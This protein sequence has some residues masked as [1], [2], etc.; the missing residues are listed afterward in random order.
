M[1]VYAVFVSAA[2]A[3]KSAQG[4]GESVSLGR[5]AV[6]GDGRK[7]EKSSLGRNLIRGA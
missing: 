3:A 7:E 2:T 5:A 6:F 1:V 4:D